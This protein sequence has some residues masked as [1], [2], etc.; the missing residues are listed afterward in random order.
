MVAF[1]RS[2]LFLALS[3]AASGQVSNGTVQGEVLDQNRNPI[4]GAKVE[5][6]GTGGGT[7]RATVTGSS[8][9]FVLPGILP[10]EY[11]LS[12]ESP[13][14]AAAKTDEFAV[15]IGQTV[16]HSIVMRPLT[17]VESIEVTERPDAIQGT[18]SNASVALGNDRIEETPAPSRN[19]LNFVLTAPGV[20][21]ASGSNARRSAASLRSAF[22]DSGFTFAGMRPRNNA[23]SIDGVDNRDETTGGNRV[24]IGLEMVAEFR[25]SGTSTGVEYGNAAG[26][27]VNVIT[28]SGTNLWHGDMTYFAQ[29]EFINARN[30]EAQVNQRPRAR[31]TQPGVSINGPAR[32][33]RTFFSTAIEQQWE[34]SEEWSEVPSSAL[35][36]INARLTRPLERGLFP[37]SGAQTEFSFKGNH[38]A[39]DRHSLAAR[40]AYSR[41]RASNDIQDIDHFTDRS[42]RGSSVTSDHSM[43][44][45]W[46]AVVRPTIVS[47]LRAQWAQRESALRP[48]STGPMVEIAGAVTFGQSWRLDT[49][50]TETH[51]EAIE[52]LQ[53]IRGKHRIQ[54]G[55]SIHRVSLDSRMANRFAG[56]VLFPTLDAFFAGTPELFLQALGDPRTRIGTTPV[57][58]WIGDKWS[59][60][61][62]ITI[63]AGLRYDRQSMPAGLPVSNRN[64]A[65]RFGIAW[66]PRGSAKWVIR[67]GT[68]LFFDR[69]PLAFLN[70]A[71]QKDGVRSREYFLTG[72]AALRAWRGN[73]IG[74]GER[75]SVY[76]AADS[77]P[78]TY[79][80]KLTAGIERSFGPDT[81]LTAEFTQL[82]GLHLPR[83]RNAALTLPAN[84]LLEQNSTSTYSGI[85]LS[86]NR[87]LS[88][89]WTYLIAWNAGRTRDD[90]SDFDEH[91]ADPA[92][93]RLDRAL[94]RQHQAHRLTASGLYETPEVDALP[95]WIREPLEEITIAPILSLGTGRPLNAISSTG[96]A[97][98]G[99]WPISARPPGMARNA[100]LTPGQF[101]IDLRVMKTFPFS[102]DRSR[103]QIGIESF[104]LTNHSNPLRFSPYYSAGSVRL[105]SFGGVVE[106][107]NA[108]QFQFLVQFEY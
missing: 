62:G 94:S 26:G 16:V 40:Y 42:A 90:A 75:A 17:V 73:G 9:R 35:A 34:S 41:G 59:A 53:W 106:T 39:N 49:D 27:S 92:N 31:R 102:N 86:L 25:V 32:R 33:D 70:D 107:L 103:L 88:K 105:P 84:Y 99:A 98:T 24:A 48:N 68:G 79:S 2:V 46:T 20:A 81:T 50:R 93:F 21:P 108:R 64:F 23:I 7:A 5:V 4:A 96:A 10:G 13:G 61:S 38:H 18:E 89:D 60:G 12:V 85:S 65:P 3:F 91:P 43:V 66:Q 58:A 45:G 87:R 72:P 6:R 63:E 95:A 8:G 55:A 30:P 52:S 19:Y 69:S 47:D 74:P 56:I 54:A 22:S 82:L 101:S 100:F 80:R 1:A 104:N 37:A 71:I 67:A 83:I 57:G 97:I 78:S 11:T 29:H 15:T 44:F 51:G 36:A 77:L 14:L 28:R 76:R